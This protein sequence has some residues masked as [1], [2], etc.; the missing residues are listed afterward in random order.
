MSLI[1]DDASK[2]SAGN[3]LM[4]VQGIGISIIQIRRLWDRL[5]FMMGIPILLKNNIFILR[6]PPIGRIVAYRLCVIYVRE[7]NDFNV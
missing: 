1:D 4:A 2:L 7:D 3:G 6:Q 5:I